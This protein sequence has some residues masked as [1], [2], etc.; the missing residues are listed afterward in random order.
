MVGYGAFRV[1]LT[2][3]LGVECLGRLS[4]RARSV[5]QV[6]QSIGR[7]V[8]RTEG[9]TWTPLP[10]ICSWR[11]KPSLFGFDREACRSIVTRSRH[12]PRGPFRAHRR[13]PDRASMSRRSASAC[14]TCQ[15]VRRSLLRSVRDGSTVEIHASRARLWAFLGLHC[16]ILGALG[17]L[18]GHFGAVSSR[19]AASRNSL[20]ECRIRDVILSGF[21]LQ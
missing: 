10:G 15:A 19:D 18:L 21:R 8:A 20:K 9:V 16:C 11:S 4:E 12:T 5:Q 3:N 7:D 17:T 1:G 2:A 14:P 6:P 13:C